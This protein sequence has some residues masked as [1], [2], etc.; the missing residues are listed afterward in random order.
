MIPQFVKRAYE[1][2]MAT[3]DGIIDTLGSRLSALEAGLQVHF[4]TASSPK[5]VLSTDNDL[6]VIHIGVTDPA[7]GLW[8]Q[9]TADFSVENTVRVRLRDTQ[10]AHELYSDTAAAA[11]Y[12]DWAKTIDADI[13]TY[14]KSKSAPKPK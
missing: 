2:A 8:T 7:L 5:V 13:L 12:K 11:L 14:R 10:T 4:K 6:P 1:E 9:Y 3:A